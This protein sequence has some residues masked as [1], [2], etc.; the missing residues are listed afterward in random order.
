MQ[1][2]HTALSYKFTRLERKL[3]QWKERLDRATAPRQINEAVRMVR[4][5]ESAI[6]SLEEEN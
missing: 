3:R 5:Y 4:L 1:V 6:I 2:T